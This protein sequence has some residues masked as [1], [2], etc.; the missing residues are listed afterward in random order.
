MEWKYIKPRNKSGGS[1]GGEPVV[2]VSGLPRSGTSMMMKMLAAGGLQ[3]MTDNIR[4]A[5]E[6]NPKGYY[7]FERV[8]KMAEG[9]TG[10]IQEAQGKAVKVISYL[11]DQMPTEYTYRIIFMQREIEEILASQRRML[12]RDGK[13][14][15]GTSDEQ[16]KELY[17]K[18]LSGVKAWLSRQP[19]IEV[20]YTS[21]NA[22]LSDPKSHT[23]EIAVFLGRDLDLQAMVNV[24]DQAL[25]RERSQN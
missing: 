15:D 2:V 13:P 17:A 25:Y 8:K 9:D 1:P 5:D 20:H 24:V 21:Y 18:H 16:M 7:E 12:E 6:N 4:I 10:W 19:N 22:I 3:L 11:L 14:D 23:Q